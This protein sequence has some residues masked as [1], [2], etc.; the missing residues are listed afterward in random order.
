MCKQKIGKSDESPYVAFNQSINGWSINKILADSKETIYIGHMK[1]K[2]W[3][4]K[5]IVDAK[6]KLAEARP[7]FNIHKLLSSLNKDRKTWLKL[8]ISKL[9]A[10]LKQS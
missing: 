1:Q 4:R 2:A 7:H 9:Q 5:Y 8:H 6:E 10:T 3:T